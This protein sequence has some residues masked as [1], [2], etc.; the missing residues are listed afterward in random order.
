MPA[1]YKD[2]TLPA[3]LSGLHIQEIPAGQVLFSPGDPCER[4]IFVIDGTVRVDLLSEEGRPVMLYRFGDGESCILTTS[5]LI[6]A[7]PY[8]AEAV[9]ETPLRAIAVPAAQFHSRLETGEDF[10]RLVFDAFALRLSEMIARMEDVTFHPLGQRLAR[11]LLARAGEGARLAATH[12]VLAQ[13]LGS[14]RE[15]VSRKLG[16]WEALGLIARHRGAVEILDRAALEA[17]TA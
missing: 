6:S 7:R 1:P 5:C 16:S 8:T 9:S 2:G 10:R 15:V 14:A 12:E 11:L 3:C 17:L 4:F 13:E